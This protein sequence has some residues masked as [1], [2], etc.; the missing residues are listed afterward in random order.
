[1]LG[2]VLSSSEHLKIAGEVKQPIKHTL[3]RFKF[4]V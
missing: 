4:P 1:M 3:M 2:E